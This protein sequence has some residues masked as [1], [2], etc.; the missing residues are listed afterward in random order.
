[1]K[2]RV[3]IF[4]LLFTILSL[5]AWAEDDSDSTEPA[6]FKVNVYGVTDQTPAVPTADRLGGRFNAVTEEQIERQGALD[7]Y[8][9]LRSVPGVIFQKRNIIGGQ[10][11]HSLYIRGRGASHP[12]PDLTV[13]FDNVPRSGALFGQALADGIPIYALG[14]MEVHKSPQ[15]SRFGS[16]YGMINFVPKYMTREG[17]NVQAG[18][19]GGSHGT[20]A[21]N[22]SLGYK[23]GRFDIFAAQTWLSTDGHVAHSAARQAGYYANTGVQLGE[24]WSIRFLGNYVQART[25]SPLNPLT[26]ERPERER[27]DTK[28]GLMTLTLANEFDN[29]SGWLKLYYNDTK[30][31]MLGERSGGID[32]AARSRQTIRLF[33]LRGRETFSLWENNEI[34]AGFDLDKTDL[35]NYTVNL[36]NPQGPDN[37]RTWDFPDQTL[38]SPYCVK[39]TAR[40]LRVAAVGSIQSTPACDA[41]LRNPMKYPG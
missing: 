32:G 13:L 7:F 3:C 24:N 38:F 2:H 25:E 35:T 21:E 6:T 28:T 36:V 41:S 27:F 16:G 1:M 37:P 17:F 18:A 39:K 11:S 30:F 22:F 34:T 33:G 12:S 9:A 20:V 26:G 14:G 40:R 8:D 23:D 15:P 4:S 19:E 29:A 5:T 10:T 31:D